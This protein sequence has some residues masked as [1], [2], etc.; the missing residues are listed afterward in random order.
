MQVKDYNYIDDADNN[1][2]QTGFIAQ[3]LYKIYPNAVQSGGEDVKTKPWMIDYSKL[4]PVLV[5]AIQEQ[6]AQIEDLKKM[7]E[8]LMR[9]LEALEKK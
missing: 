1:N 4:A 3:E 9:R 5:K 7:N 6:Q 8:M 2:V